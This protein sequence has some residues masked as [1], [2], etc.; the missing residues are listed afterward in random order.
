M[1]EYEKDL[2]LA[3]SYLEKKNASFSQLTDCATR[4]R[5]SAQHLSGPEQ[6]ATIGRLRVT[7]QALVEQAAAMQAS[8]LDDI[9]KAT[10]ARNDSQLAEALESFGSTVSRLRNGVASAGPTLIIRVH[11]LTGWPVRQIKARLNMPCLPSMHK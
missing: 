3:R 1:N 7:A 11:D 6:L 5:A 10:G 4:L 8:L 9:M 2:E